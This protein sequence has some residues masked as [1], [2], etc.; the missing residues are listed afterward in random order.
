MSSSESEKMATDVGDVECFMW[1]LY[2]SA[3]CEAEVD[4]RKGAEECCEPNLG[5]ECDLLRPPV[6]K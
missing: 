5:C 4:W 3:M 1:W 6:W 2:E